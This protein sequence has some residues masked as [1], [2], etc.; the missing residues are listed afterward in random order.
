[1]GLSR[2]GW[3][4]GIVVIAVL[5]A[6]GG[7]WWISL[8]PSVVSVNDALNDY[9]AR[10]S[11]T[12]VGTSIGASLGAGHAVVPAGVYTYITNGREALDGPLTESHIY[13]AESAI[14]ITE[15]ECGFD[16]R[17]DVFERRSDTNIWCWINDDLTESQSTTDHIFFKVHDKRTFI[18]E[19]VA[20]VLPSPTST[21]SMT[22]TC[23]GS[24]TVNSRTA[25]LV[26]KESLLVGKDVVDA[27]I[28]T[29]TDIAGK[30][31]SGI[32]TVTL[33]LRPSDGLII[34]MHRVA[35]IKNDSIIGAIH[36]TEDITLTL[37]SLTPQK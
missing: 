12:M 8:D 4:G 30:K 2:R 25:K 28:V 1:V 10:A 20:V 3:F 17:W 19:P 6:C 23:T 22:S 5:L 35:D 31:S 24:D 15:S 11:T 33:W 29:A 26:G 37:A 34:K 16:W 18:C 27:V 13:P 14:T 7:W 9:R 32:S 36:Y 21:T